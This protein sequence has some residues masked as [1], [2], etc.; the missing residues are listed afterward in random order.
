MSLRQL[1]IRIAT[2]LIGCLFGLLMFCFMRSLCYGYLFVIHSC[3]CYSFVNHMLLL[4]ICYH[5]FVYIYIYIHMVY[6]YIYIYTYYVYI[7][8]YIYIERR[9]P[10]RLLGDGRLELRGGLRRSRGQRLGG[11]I[12]LICYNM[13]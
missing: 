4:C 10:H 5:I 3:Y 13:T 7:Y 1:N 6:I 12:R 2:C 9:G 8:I 11:R